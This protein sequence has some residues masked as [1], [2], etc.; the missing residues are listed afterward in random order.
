M[1]REELSSRITRLDR[2]S[3]GR[4]FLARAGSAARYRTPYH[5]R[6]T[7]PAPTSPICGGGW[8]WSMRR[9]KLSPDR[10]SL[11]ELRLKKNSSG[12]YDLKPVRITQYLNKAPVPTLAGDWRLA[13]AEHFPTGLSQHELWCLQSAIADYVSGRLVLTNPISWKVVLYDLRALS[14]ASKSLLGEI[15]KRSPEDSIWQRVL[16]ET[17]P[18]S[19]ALATVRSFLS[20]LSDATRAALS[21]A[22]LEKNEGVSRDY[23]E[24]WS[25]LVNELADLFELKV[26]K[27][28]AAKNLRN[29]AAARPSPFVEFVWTVVTSAVPT[30]LRE[31]TASKNAM[32]K[33]VS[34]VLVRAKSGKGRPTGPFR[35]ILYGINP[36]TDE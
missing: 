30:Q 2:A 1:P 8:R 22:E 33:A 3:H 11:I 9:K 24:P 12:R 5:R 16:K 4:L 27:A 23:K 32:S 7:C 21:K 14:T 17:P 13:V 19:L 15:N 25:R 18:A 28:T 26:G 6:P 34:D 36:V 35:E 20:K 10:T 29:L 31:H